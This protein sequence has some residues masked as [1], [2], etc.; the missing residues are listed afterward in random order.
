MTNVIQWSYIIYYET[1]ENLK[2]KQKKKLV[3]KD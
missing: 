2:V 3:Y 1:S